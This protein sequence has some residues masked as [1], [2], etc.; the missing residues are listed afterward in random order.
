MIDEHRQDLAAEYALGA[1]DPEATLAFEAL[2]A[3]DRELK[4]LADSLRETAAALAH[5]A[6]AQLPPPE[7]RERI[8]ARVRAEASTPAS[9]SQPMTQA[10]APTQSSGGGNL[11]PWALAAGFAI[12]TAAFWVERGQ[13][14]QDRDALLQDRKEWQARDTL[15]KVKIATLSAQVEAYAKASAVI[16]WDPERQRG[17]LKLANIPQPASGKDYQLW[18]IDPKYPQPVSG[19]IVTVDAGGLAHVF[20]EPKKPISKSDKFAISVE[21]AGGMPEPTGPIVLLSSN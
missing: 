11:L 15:A 13:L 7:L 1:L 12:S 19:G 4:A 3:N 20:F 8:L 18:V 6:P 5:D 14:Q 2:L 9:T 10:N 16:V 17:V 21:P